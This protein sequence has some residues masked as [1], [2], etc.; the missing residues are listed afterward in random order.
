VCASPAEAQV[1]AA[2]AAAPVD[3]QGG[4]TVTRPA[5]LSARS[6]LAAGCDVAPNAVRLME[7]AGPRGIARLTAALARP[8]NDDGMKH[9]VVVE[10][11]EQGKG[12]V[13]C[14]VCD[15]MIGPGRLRTVWT[16]HLRS[17]AHQE[18]LRVVAGLQSGL[19]IVECVNVRTCLRTHP[20]FNKHSPL[21][22][23]LMSCP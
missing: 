15:L 2:A 22:R 12:Q 6:T 19:R 23:S 1:G 10:C 9:G 14:G 21:H 11:E 20:T 18:R 8:A 17:K 3:A 13:F 4:A 7:P 5:P 16:D